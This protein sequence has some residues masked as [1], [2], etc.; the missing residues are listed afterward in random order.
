LFGLFAE[1]PEG[2]REQFVEVKDEQINKNGPEI[3]ARMRIA[4]IIDTSD[5]QSLVEEHNHHDR[6]CDAQ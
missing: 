3:V 2:R 5:P 4:V 6:A 1:A